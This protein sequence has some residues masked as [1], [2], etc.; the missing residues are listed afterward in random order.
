MTDAELKQMYNDDPNFKIYVDKCRKNNNNS[1]EE[2]LKL[3]TIQFVAE[4]YQGKSKP[5]T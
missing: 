5:C 3:I 2:E 1:V 4:F